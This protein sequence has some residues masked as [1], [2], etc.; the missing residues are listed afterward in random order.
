MDLIMNAY[1]FYLVGSSRNSVNLNEVDAR[2][3]ANV[4]NSAAVR[5]WERSDL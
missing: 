3:H 1:I 4:S 5:E 2:S